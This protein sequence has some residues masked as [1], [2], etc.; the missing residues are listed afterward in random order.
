MESRWDKILDK[1]AIAFLRDGFART[2]IEK[3]SHWTV[4]KRESPSL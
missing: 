3:I 2:G 1:A 4:M